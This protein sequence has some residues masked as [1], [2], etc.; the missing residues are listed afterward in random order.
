MNNTGYTSSSPRLN[1]DVNFAAAGTYYVWVRGRDSEATAGNSDSVHVGLDESSAGERGSDPSPFPTT[2]TWTKATMDGADATIQVPSAG[3]HTVN[4]WMRED[5][6]IFDKLVL[7]SS[8]SYTP[9]GDG[10]AETLPATPTCSDGVQ[11]G[12]E[13]GIDCGGTCPACRRRPGRTRFGSK[14][15]P[16]SQRQPRI[17]ASIEHR[18]FRRPV[19]VSAQRFLAQRAR[20]PTHHLQLHDRCRHLQGLGTGDR[21]DG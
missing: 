1:F 10:P 17:C 4:V 21:A 7:S 8:S 5:G 3:Q 9:S 19:P 20:Q 14:Q 15:R 16:S 6:F 13:T 2:L 11:N 12:S 18:S